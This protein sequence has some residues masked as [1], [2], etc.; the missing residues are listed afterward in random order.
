MYSIYSLLAVRFEHTQSALSLWLSV[1]LRANFPSDHTHMFSAAQLN[2]EQ[3][4]CRGRSAAKLWA[5]LIPMPCRATYPRAASTVQPWQRF[6]NSRNSCWRQLP[7]RSSWL[8]SSV[9]KPSFVPPALGIKIIDF[10]VFGVSGFDLSA[11]DLASIQHFT[12]LCHW[13][14]VDMYTASDSDK[15]NVWFR[16]SDVLL[17]QFFADIDASFVTLRTLK[18]SCR[19]WHG[20][21]SGSGEEFQV[22]SRTCMQWM[23]TLFT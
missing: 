6:A 11:G 10:G 23:R 1:V 3:S 18:N 8:M 12:R 13:V 22:H 17:L 2:L 21:I 7:S 9:E 16:K 4:C 15:M 20:K 19:W 14:I 5:F